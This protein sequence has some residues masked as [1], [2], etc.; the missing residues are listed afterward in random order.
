ME[1]DF[2]LAR[3]EGGQ[4]GFHRN[5]PSPELVAHEGEFLGTGPHR[6]LVP[7][8]GKSVDLA[9]LRA[10][11]HEVVGA[12]LAEQA[13]RAFF[14]EQGL[15]PI[16]TVEAP[17]LR[18]AADGIIVWCGD[19]FAL[20]PAQVGAIDRVWDR[21][22]LIAL[23]PELRIRYAAQLATLAPGA[24]VLLSTLDYGPGETTG[25]PFAVPQAEIARLYGRGVRTLAE[26]DLLT[27]ESRWA[28]G[29]HA[30]AKGTLST[31]ALPAGTS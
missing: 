30:W 18:F 31:F 29:G 5:V 14:D 25:P 26:E 7:L 21:A 15:V 9:W 3:W 28:T 16:V 1:L 12:E 10:R 2:W 22:A 17:F 19:L 4:I 8:C 6:V 11:G 24:I 13:V 27:E 20:A 23:P